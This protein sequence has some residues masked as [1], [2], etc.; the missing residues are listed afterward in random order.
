MTTG[1]PRRRKRLSVPSAAAETRRQPAD[2]AVPIE[3]GL[4]VPWI[5]SWS[6]PLQP[7]GRFGWCPESPNAYQP[8]G[9]YGSPVATRSVHAEAAGRR[10]GGRCADRRLEHHQRPA[11]LHQRDRPAREI[12]LDP[13]RGVRHGATGEADPAGLAIRPPGQH[14]P[15]PS[16][17]AG[18]RERPRPAVR[19]ERA[20]GCHRPDGRATGPAPHGGSGRVDDRKRSGRTGTA[21]LATAIR[22]ARDRRP[23]T[24]RW[25]RSGRWRAGR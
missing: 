20:G 6:P 16:V 1:V 8:N 25:W 17:V 15:C 24:A 13:N 4:L 14:D 7:A 12:G 18:G 2:A 10:G 21:A 5:A 11:A 19:S 9:P 3:A 22:E 23:R